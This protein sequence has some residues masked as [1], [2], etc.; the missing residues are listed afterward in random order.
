MSAEENPGHDDLFSE[1]NI[2]E[3]KENF[4][5]DNRMVMVTGAKNQ[6]DRFSLGWFTKNIL[7]SL[8]H[9]F[10]IFIFYQLI[11]FLSHNL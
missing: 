2:D 4:L 11:F 8:V 10:Y 5:V 1:N 9:E 6:E 7:I 3:N